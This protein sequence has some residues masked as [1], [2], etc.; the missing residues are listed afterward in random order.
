MSHEYLYY[1]KAPSDQ[2]CTGVIQ[3]LFSSFRKATSEPETKGVKAC[4]K[5]IT[6]SRIFFLGA[7][8]TLEIESWIEA[9]T[10]VCA[11]LW[12]EENKLA[13]VNTLEF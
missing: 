3:L 2:K 13:K 6:P 7:D 10:T 4:F 11:K 1:F 9:L 8:S 12:E 5:I